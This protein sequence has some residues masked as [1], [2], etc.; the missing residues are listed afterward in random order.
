MRIYLNTSVLVAAVYADDPRH[1]CA[2]WFLEKAAASHRLYMSSI[3]G[4][5]GFRE[6]TRARIR[7]LRRRYGIR[8]LRID[9]DATIEWAERYV[10]RA[11]LSW[12]R[13]MDVAHLRAAQ[14]LGMDAVASF[15][16]FINRRAK[17][18]GLK[19][20]NM[21]EWCRKHGRQA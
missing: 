9:V 1:T 12:K 5:E 15:D 19:P 17:L 2:A 18:F 21:Y 10:S 3:H 13:V 16:R 11:G 14:V 20:I 4:K 8:V 7:R 6:E